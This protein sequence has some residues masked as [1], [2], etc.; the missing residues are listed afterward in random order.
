MEKDVIDEAVKKAFTPEFRNRLTKTVTFNHISADMAKAIVQK[1]LGQF[2]E[3]LA[4]KQIEISFA[5][6]AIK[7]IAEKGVSA[8]YGAREI[9]RIIDGQIKPLLVEEILFGKLAKGG[10]CKIDLAEEEFKIKIEQ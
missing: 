6:R 3:Q 4:T 2:K 10:K 9:I 1:Q 7:F 5:P 8:E